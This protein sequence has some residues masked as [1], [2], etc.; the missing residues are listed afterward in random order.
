MEMVVKS[1]DKYDC[2]NDKSGKWQL[3]LYTKDLDRV[4]RKATKL[5]RK[6]ELTGI[7][8]LYI[9][10]SYANRAK[11]IYFKCSPCDEENVVKSY[12]R[13]LLKHL[14][15]FCKS[16]AIYYMPSTQNIRFSYVLRLDDLEDEEA[17]GPPSIDLKNDQEDS[18]INM[19]KKM[20]FRY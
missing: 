19:L 1:Y 10:T 16:D 8:S 17:S 12:G 5:Y 13:N 3:Q 18:V 4:W 7:Q 14:G 9:N 15:N 11:A 20:T 6:E 2:G